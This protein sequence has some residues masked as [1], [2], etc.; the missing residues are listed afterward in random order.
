MMLGLRSTAE[1]LCLAGVIETLDVIS[2]S[3]PA[4]VQEEGIQ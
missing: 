4:P 1:S 3:I 2:A